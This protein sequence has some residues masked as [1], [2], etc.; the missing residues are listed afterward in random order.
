MYQHDINYLNVWIAFLCISTKNH[1]YNKIPTLNMKYFSIIAS[2]IQA[3]IL[4]ICT[5]TYEIIPGFMVGELK[6]NSWELSKFISPT[7]KMYHEN[8]NKNNQRK[9]LSDTIV[10]SS[11]TSK[12]DGKYF[13]SYMTQM[14]ILFNNQYAGNSQANMNIL[15]NNFL[16]FNEFTSMVFNRCDLIFYLPCFRATYNIINQMIFFIEW[17]KWLCFN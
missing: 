10:A 3:M 17:F 2:M 7:N 16:E 4:I 8:D 9:N 12:L 15:S 13:G 1:C 5:S 6:M 14:L 11:I